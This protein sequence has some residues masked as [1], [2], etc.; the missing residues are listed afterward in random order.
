MSKHSFTLTSHMHRD[1]ANSEGRVKTFEIGINWKYFSLSGISNILDH[2]W[3]GDNYLT[4]PQATPP[5][6]LKEDQVQSL[7]LDAFPRKNADEAG[8]FLPSFDRTRK[9]LQNKLKFLSHLAQGKGGD[10]YIYIYIY[11][12]IQREI[13]R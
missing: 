11:I 7:V 3:R 4:H 1:I 8:L 5:L 12:Y 2:W 13:E 6:N 10:E 9:S